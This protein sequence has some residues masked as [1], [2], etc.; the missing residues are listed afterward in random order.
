MHR[1]RAVR[2]NRN[3]LRQRFHA[4]EEL[5]CLAALALGV[6]KFS[7]QYLALMCDWYR[8]QAETLHD[9]AWLK[10]R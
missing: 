1:F 3:Y 10:M 7:F 5:I 2:L 9:N 6:F 8:L 4:A